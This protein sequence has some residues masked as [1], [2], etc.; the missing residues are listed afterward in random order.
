MMLHKL[1]PELNIDS[2]LCEINKFITHFK[3]KEKFPRA[4]AQGSGSANSVG[5][6]PATGQTGYTALRNRNVAQIHPMND[7]PA[8][9]IHARKNADVNLNDSNHASFNDEDDD[10]DNEWQSQMFDPNAAV[11]IANNNDK[12][13]QAT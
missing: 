8:A 9:L 7:N 3:F 5:V 10:S 12:V 13:N 11:V 4:N 2:E 6:Q 1:R